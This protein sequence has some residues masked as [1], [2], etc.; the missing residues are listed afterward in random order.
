[1]CIF[2]AGLPGLKW[3][4]KEYTRESFKELN[5]CYPFSKGPSAVQLK[6]NE[7]IMHHEGKCF[8]AWLKLR[9]HLKTHPEDASLLTPLTP[10]EWVEKSKSLGF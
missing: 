9:L 4:A 8:H 3:G 6:R 2:C 5:G 1:M 7:V 10:A